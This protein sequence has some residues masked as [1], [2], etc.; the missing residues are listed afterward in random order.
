MTARD[1]RPGVV[2]VAHDGRDDVLALLGDLDPGLPVVVADA[3]SRDGTAAAVRAAAA[4]RDLRLLELVNTGYGRAA[5]AGVRA[6]PATVDVALVLNADVRLDGDVP[7]RLAARLAADPALGAVGPRVRY[8]SGAAQASARRIPTLGTAVLHGL[9]GWWWPGNPA[10]RGYR[11]DPAAHRTRDGQGGAGAAVP[12]DW[13]SGCA[14]AVRRTAFAAVG[15]F[16]P[17]YRLFVEDVD[18]CDRLA[19]AGWRVALVPDV[20]V[21]H[22]VGGATAARPLR[23]RLAHARGL[24]R[25]VAQRLPAAARPAAVLLRPALL[26]WAVAAAAAT[27]VRRGRRSSTGEVHGV[28]AVPA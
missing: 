9:L 18:L 8:P 11:A 13:V 3:G 10:T 2:I 28:R 4:G 16:D 25:F 15:G 21:T 27:V 26:L 19:A 24:E 20:A 23:A 12:V 5:N 14:V 17:G 1:V 7:H 22:R 6:L